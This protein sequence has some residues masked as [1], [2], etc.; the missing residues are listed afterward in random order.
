[1]LNISGVYHYTNNK[2][3]NKQVKA[4]LALILIATALFACA[5]VQNVKFIRAQ[6]Y[7]LPGDSMCSFIRK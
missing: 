5:A 1:M 2:L 7:T 4:S 6:S 3:K